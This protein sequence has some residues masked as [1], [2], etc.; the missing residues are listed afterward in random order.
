MACAVKMAHLET[1]NTFFCER[2][3]AVAAEIFQAV[4]DTVSEYQE[5]IENSKREIVYLRKT[6][7]EVSINAGADA[8]TSQ[9][10]ELLLEQQNTHLEPPDPSVIQV[11]LECSSVEQDSETQQLL[12][13]NCCMS[14]EEAKA[15]E[16]PHSKTGDT[17]KNDDIGVCMGSNVT[18]KLER[19]S[20]ELNS[21]AVQTESLWTQ[22]QNSEDE[23]G[24][25]HSSQ[26][27]F[28]LQQFHMRNATTENLFNYK[29]C[30]KPFRGGLLKTHMI[31]HHKARTYRC[32]LC[33]KCYSTSYALKLHLR[34]HTGE[35]PYTC[36]YCV[37]T[38]N[39][40]AHVKEHER[41]HT[42]E[43]PYSC[44]VCGKRFNR[45][46]QVKVHIR[47]YHPDDVATIIK[48]RQCK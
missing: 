35:R 8:Q 47:N 33:G 36:K 40:K 6:L 48:S 19:C 28:S 4:K 29:P 9:R 41:I 38:F 18:V 13:D 30:G 31:M 39:Q 37:K 23:P 10:D 14:T 12:S 7:A 5:E 45:T 22:F 44:S 24:P 20:D 42:G 15:T 43:K 25:H 3:L 11:K 26:C 21:C 27:D 17:E 32:D 2:L 46:Y 1:L 34:T 16:V